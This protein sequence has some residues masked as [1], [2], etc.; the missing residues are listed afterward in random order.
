ME[1]TIRSLS[2]LYSIIWFIINLENIN[3]QNICWVWNIST[4]YDAV[5]VANRCLQYWIGNY[6][7]VSILWLIIYPILIDSLYCFILQI[8]SSPGFIQLDKK[9][10]ELGLSKLHSIPPSQRDSLLSVSIQFKWR[11][12]SFI[13]HPLYTIPPSRYLILLSIM[14]SIH[15]VHQPLVEGKQRN[16][17]LALI[18]SVINNNI[19]CSL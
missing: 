13:V 8:I 6:D 1:L 19:L 5:S 11:D 16:D 9:N 7:R 2:R 15:T 14:L 12:P 17:I 18:D 10:L 3:I 4:Q